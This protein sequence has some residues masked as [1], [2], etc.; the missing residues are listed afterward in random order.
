VTEISQL[1]QRDRHGLI[2]EIANLSTIV[3]SYFKPVK[4]NVGSLG[5]I[6]AQLHVHL[7]ARFTQD[8]AWPFGIWQNNVPADEPYTNPSQ[9]IDDLSQLIAKFQA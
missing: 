2:D 1:S 5:N 6:V 3:E 9:L 7:V 4:I 8:V